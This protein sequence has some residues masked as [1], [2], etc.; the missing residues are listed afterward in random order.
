MNQTY[1]NFQIAYCFGGIVA[2]FLLFLTIRELKKMDHLQ[3]AIELS[4]QLSHEIAE[5]FYYKNKYE[6]L[7]RKTDEPEIS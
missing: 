5:K 4:V 2:L 7:K 1:I 3:S 6:A